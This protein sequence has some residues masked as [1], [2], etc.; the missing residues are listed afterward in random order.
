MSLNTLLTP[1]IKKAVALLFDVHI[2]TVEFQATR[3]DF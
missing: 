3:R 1:E 2:E